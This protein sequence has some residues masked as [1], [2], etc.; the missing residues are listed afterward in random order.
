MFKRKSETI[1][2]EMKRIKT[3]CKTLKDIDSIH[4]WLDF[5]YKRLT[6]KEIDAE[7]ATKYNFADIISKGKEVARFDY[8]K[9][10]NTIAFEF[11][12]YPLAPK[13][14]L[15]VYNEFEGDTQTHIDIYA[16]KVWELY[17]IGQH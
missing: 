10:D 11:L 12:N 16:L 1:K 7:T 14:F 6:N 9:G 17:Y 2:E 8:D 3:T 5:Y 13:N 15:L 4:R